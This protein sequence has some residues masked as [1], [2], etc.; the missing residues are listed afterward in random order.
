V[1]I[2]PDSQVSRDNHPAGLL[3]Q[4]RHPSFIRRVRRKT[5]LQMNNFVLWF[6]EHMQALGELD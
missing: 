4:N 6:D 2:F 1:R 5:I 3:R